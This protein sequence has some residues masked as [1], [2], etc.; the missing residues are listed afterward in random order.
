MNP[1][2]KPFQVRS[3]RSYRFALLAVFGITGLVL[4]ASSTNGLWRQKGQ[5]SQAETKNVPVSLVMPGEKH[6]A[7]VRQLTP[8]G[9]N[10]EAYFSANG[11]QLIFQS[12]RDGRGC[13]AEYIMNADGSGLRMVSTGKGRTTCGYFLPSGKRVIYASTHL[14]GDP[15]PPPPD[16]SKGYVWALYP[17]FDIFSANPD[18][19]DV[20]R[21]TDNPGYDAEGTVSPDGKHI[22]FT[23]LRDGDIDIYTMTPDGMNVK[24]LTTELGYDGG[25]FY[26]PDGKKIVYRAS[27]PKP[28]EEVK[29][30]RELLAVNMIRPHTLEL[31]IMDADGKNKRQLTSNRAANFA[32]FMLPNGRQ[33]I[34]SSNMDD[35]KGRNFE[36]YL[37]NADGSALER[38]TF[39][40]TFDGFPMLSPDGKK[41]VFASNRNAQKRG[42]TNIFIADW[43]P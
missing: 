6:L 28:E 30:Y 41:L 24:R 35:P 14:G 31:F 34:F 10:A 15:C 3:R 29:T 4:A 40:D 5:A 16:F 11:K 37:I 1:S 7:Q 18:G 21:L 12:T 9:E 17:S 42:D 43:T 23:S 36:L 32:P 27:R 38:V 26:S 2:V 8:G 33:I 22:V 25:A 13:D 39:N 19:A 20:K